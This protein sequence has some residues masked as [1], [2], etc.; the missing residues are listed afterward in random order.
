M[1][2]QQKDVLIRGNMTYGTEIG[3]E[4]DTG[5]DFQKREPESLKV[6]GEVC[7][8]LHLPCLLGFCRFILSSCKR[9]TVPW[10]STLMVMVW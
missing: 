5:M 9:K 7:C 8:A 1:E 6:P 3:M 2:S 4:R 10:K